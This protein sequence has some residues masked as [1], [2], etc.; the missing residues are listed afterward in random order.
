[1][2]YLLW[3]VVALTAYASVHIAKA[4]SSGGGADNISCHPLDM[5][6]NSTSVMSL[7]GICP[8]VLFFFEDCKRDLASASADRR[9][10]SAHCF[11]LQE[12]SRHNYK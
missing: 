3:N 9:L 4:D 12:F 10:Y 1:M 6:G 11:E 7:N 5:E 8:Q 2:N